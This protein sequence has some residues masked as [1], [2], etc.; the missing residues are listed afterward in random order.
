MAHGP[1]TSFNYYTLRVFFNLSPMLPPVFHRHFHNPSHSQRCW[2]SH[3]WKQRAAGVCHH[4]GPGLFLCGSSDRSGPS[5]TCS[6]HS[7]PQSCLPD[8]PLQLMITLYTVN[9][10]G[11]VRYHHMSSVDKNIFNKHFIWS[12]QKTKVAWSHMFSNV[13]ILKWLRLTG[14]DANFKRRCVAVKSVAVVIFAPCLAP[15]STRRP[16]DSRTWYGQRDS[17]WVSGRPPG[18]RHGGPSGRLIREHN[19][20]CEAERCQR[21]PPSLQTE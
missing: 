7:S 10:S 4:S 2:W 13:L 21:Q 9:P 11:A 8:M 1:F 6:T 18:Q 20:H 16:A 5:L 3:I 15:R 14:F 19:H 12:V 17:G